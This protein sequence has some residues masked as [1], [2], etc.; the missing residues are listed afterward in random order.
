MPPATNEEQFRFLISCIRWS[1]NGKVDFTEVAKE[2]QVVSKGA[3]AKRYERMMRAH[4]IHPNGGPGRAPTARQPKTERNAGPS[5][6]KKA[7]GKAAAFDES[8]NVDDDEEPAGSD[9]FKAEN[10]QD[11]E[12]LVINFQ[13]YCPRPQPTSP[14][15]EYRKLESI[16]MAP[17]KKPKVGTKSATGSEAKNTI[18]RRRNSAAKVAVGRPTSRSPQKR[19]AKSNEDDGVGDDEPPYEPSD[20]EIDGDSTKGNFHSS[21]VTKATKGRKGPVKSAK[22][23]IYKKHLRRD[24]TKFT[25]SQAMVDAEE[26]FD[27][28]AAAYR[29]KATQSGG[30]GRK[31]GRRL[32]RWTAQTD[33]LLLLCLHHELA[34]NKEELPYEAIAQRMF[35]EKNATGGAIKERFAKLRIEC[36][37]RGSWVPP[38]LGKT[39]QNTRPDVRGVVRLAPG[40][41]KGRFVLWKEDAS[42]LI[43]PKDINKGHVDAQKKG[44][45][46]PER[47]W[48]SPGAE[49]E[50]LKST[51]AHKALNLSPISGPVP[52]DDDELLSDEDEEE[53]MEA[54]SDD[55]AVVPCTPKKRKATV[56]NDSSKKKPRPV[57]RS[58]PKKITAKGRATQADESEYEGTTAGAGNNRLSPKKEPG[59]GR[60]RSPR[61]RPKSY[62]MTPPDEDSDSSATKTAESSDGSEDDESPTNNRLMM[63]AFDKDEEAR[64]LRSIVIVRGFTPGAL[65]KFPPGIQGPGDDDYAD[66]EVAEGP[67]IQ[68][69][70]DDDYADDQVAEGPTAS[71][72]GSESVIDA[73][74]DKAALHFEDN[75]DIEFDDGIHGVGQDGSMDEQN[76]NLQDLLAAMN[77]NTDNNGQLINKDLWEIHVEQM[78]ALKGAGMQ[79]PPPAQS[80]HQTQISQY[81]QHQTQNK[82]TSNGFGSFPGNF[83]GPQVSFGGSQIRFGD[84]DFQPMHSDGIQGK[85]AY[86]NIKNFIENGM[87]DT[88][89]YEKM[90]GMESNSSGHIKP[91]PVPA[92]FSGFDATIAPV[93]DDEFFSPDYVGGGEASLDGGFGPLGPLEGYF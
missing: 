85:A 34:R 37:N 27:P 75:P 61:G 50:Y 69:P 79:N 84:I 19:P 29:G 68:G 35:P 24:A 30:N 60:Y 82:L 17:V 81:I 11:E 93:R 45:Q 53:E 86:Y 73:D 1:N 14:F 44:L 64:P 16:A 87:I 4:G 76:F 36:L 33:Q 78:N 26:E 40:I 71:Y 10:S 28:R 67:G 39:P 13:A 7:K 25:T 90:K 48:I 56:I 77:R 89:Q 47:V 54:V 42:K 41:D 51:H 92:G 43:D 3:A 12:L 15:I 23:M 74:D 18:A 72:N 31:K 21:P 65:S 63:M 32:I 55:G 49:K 46:Y 38:I 5:P 20:D 70:G 57:A 62:D 91:D 58:S 52:M 6:T 9:N 88:A 59:A 80:R 83:G 8:M 22:K 2:C 66:D